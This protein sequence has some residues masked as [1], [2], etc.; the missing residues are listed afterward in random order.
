MVKKVKD[1]KRKLELGCGFWLD[2]DPNFDETFG[3][4]LINP[5]KNK[6]IKIADL[7]IEPIPFPDNHFDLLESTDFLEHIPKLIYAPQRRYALVELMNEI[8][9]VLKI[10]GIF[11]ITF[12]VYP[13]TQ[14]FD[15]PTH[16]TPLTFKTMLYFCDDGMSN[17]TALYYGFKGSLRIDNFHYTPQ[18]QIRAIIVKKDNNTIRTFDYKAMS[19]NERYKY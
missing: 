8:S 1:I 9:R 5:T 19:N 2:Q 17:L 6:N 3:I 11:D 10:G 18:E 4:D 7:N 12:P 14:A 15:D 13:N 16:I